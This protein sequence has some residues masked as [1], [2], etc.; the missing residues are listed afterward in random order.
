MESR[1]L[2][3]MLLEEMSEWI[4]VLEIEEIVTAGDS[5]RSLRVCVDVC[6]VGRE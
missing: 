6:P 4:G 1:S 5:V 2:S 3:M